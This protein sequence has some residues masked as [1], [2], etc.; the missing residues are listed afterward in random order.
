[1]GKI[2]YLKYLSDF[3]KS[4]SIMMNKANE[5]ICGVVLHYLHYLHSCIL[6]IALFALLLAP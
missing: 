2:K 3:F 6:H 4:S 1:M 5:D